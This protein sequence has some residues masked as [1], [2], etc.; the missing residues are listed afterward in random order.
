[1]S[2]VHNLLKSTPGLKCLARANLKFYRQGSLK[3]CS[4]CSET[5]VWTKTMIKMIEKLVL[6][7]IPSI[8]SVLDQ[9]E[10]YVK[11]SEKSTSG[12][13]RELGVLD[14]PWTVNHSQ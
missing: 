6:I 4:A 10:G 2:G 8:T 13:L 14:H 5:V 7:V 9:A 3:D 1:M 12:A 11:G